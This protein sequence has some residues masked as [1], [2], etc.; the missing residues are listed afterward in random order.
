MGDGRRPRIGPCRQ[1]CLKQKARRRTSISQTLEGSLVAVLGNIKS[2]SKRKGWECDVTI[3]DLVTIWERQKGCCF[4]TGQ[5]M[6][7]QRQARAGHKTGLGGT[8][9]R[10]CP[11]IVSP[12]RLDSSLPYTAENIVLCRWVANLIKSD[13]EMPL[14]L[15]TCAEFVTTNAQ[16]QQQT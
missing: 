16:R 7:F 14:L 5:P 13:L 12:D 11:D 10:C 9:V 15:K 2:R 4:H 6:K 3:Q 1:C 8:G